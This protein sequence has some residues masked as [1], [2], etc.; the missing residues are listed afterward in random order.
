MEENSSILVN[1]CSQKYFKDIFASSAKS[2][3]FISPILNIIWANDK[4]KNIFGDNYPL[5][6]YKPETGSFSAFTK[7]LT[8]KDTHGTLIFFPILFQDK[9]L[10]YIVLF[11]RD[12]KGTKPF[13]LNAAKHDLNNLLT[14]V[15]NLIPLTDKPNLANSGLEMAK[16]FLDNFSFDKSNSAELINI[17]N[18]LD[19]VFRSVIESSSGAVAFK[20]DIHP[21]LYRV[22]INKTKF[23]RIISNL[24]KN[25]VEAIQAEGQITLSAFNI[26]ERKKDFVCIIVEDTGKGIPAKELNKIFNKDYSTKNRGSGLGL[27][28]VKKLTD[29][30]GASIEVKSKESSGT[31]FKL[32]LPASAGIIKRVALIEDEAAINELLTDLLSSY[33]S[34]SSFLDAE[35][36]LAE[37]DKGVFDLIIVDKK[38]PGIDGIK[39]IKKIRAVNN[40]VKIILASGSE[41]EEDKKPALPAIDRI[42]NKPYKFDQLLSLVDELLA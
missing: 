14:I 36:F 37:K 26:N 9:F 5:S 24:L 13:E 6:D 29:E 21:G 33:Y 17:N 19:L 38:L 18:T 35:S 8:A 27:N 15:F 31:Q 30:I 12:K 7:Q 39:C 28:I 20:S 41:L 34:V 11:N 3:A 32:K 40:K 16:D 10:G 23:I 42:I 1:L 22:R 4:F 2:M 25:A